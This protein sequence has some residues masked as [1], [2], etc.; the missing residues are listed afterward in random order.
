MPRDPNGKSAKT[1][2]RRMALSRERRAALF[3]WRAALERIARADDDPR[4][5]REIAYEALSIPAPGLPPNGAPTLLWQEQDMIDELYRADLRGGWGAFDP[6]FDA[7]VTANLVRLGLVE[8][9]ADGG[10][11]LA[12]LSRRSS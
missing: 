1:D 6:P 10:L 2:A 7:L 8:A 3:A 11:R 9:R 4:A 5:M 12:A